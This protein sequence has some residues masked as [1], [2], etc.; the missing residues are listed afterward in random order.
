[1]FHSNQFVIKP[2]R[3]FICVESVFSSVVVMSAE[4]LF[5]FAQNRN[6]SSINGKVQH[7]FLVILFISPAVIIPFSTPVLLN[8]VVVMY[9]DDGY[10]LRFEP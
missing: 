10:T 4:T 9:H 2:F 8:V 1:M 7:L 6:R 5:K 3:L